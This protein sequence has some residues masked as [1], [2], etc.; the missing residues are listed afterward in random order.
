MSKMLRTTA[1]AALAVAFGAVLLTDVRAAGQQADARTTAS[2][3][4]QSRPLLDQY[5]VG[6]HNDKLKTG[7][8][9]LERIDPNTVAGHED[10]LEK[11][12]RK[13][14]S[15]QMPPEGRPR[16]DAGTLEVFATSLEKA[17]D[18]IAS[19]S[20]NPGRVVSHR[21]N[22][23]EYVNVIHDLLAMDVDGTGLLPSDMAGFGFDNNADVL[24]ITPGLMSRYITAATK[25]SRLAVASPDNRTITQVYKVEFGTRQDAR[26]GEDMP[27]ATHGGLA[28]RHAFPLDGEYA[29]AIRLKKNGT[30]STI[31]GIEEDEHQIE[32]RIDHVLVKQ[33]RIGGKFKGPDPGVLIAVS[34]DDVEGRNVHDYRVGADKELE[35][36][37]PIKAGSRLVSVAFSDSMPS[38]GSM[39]GDGR[40]VVVQGMGS[41]A[42]VDMVH[43]SGP[44]GGKTPEE[45]PSRPHI[46]T[47]PPATSRAH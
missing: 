15:G 43:V 19:A 12:V 28:V 24:S 9:T 2:A 34:E 13:L 21:L 1:A 14:R 47:C 11:V 29:F 33:F 46:F 35:I 7:G 41:Q 3:P 4:T 6:C 45:T 31:D 44:F 10:V 37:L 27:F 16:P 32:L 39:V 17:L 25:I 36:R 40:R 18:R 5:C 8:L 22:R 20:P 26:M 23:G 42:G 38:P 30:V